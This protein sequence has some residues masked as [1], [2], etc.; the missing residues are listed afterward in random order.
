MNK[1][2]DKEVMNFIKNL[3]Q[4]IEH[5][6]VTD[7]DG[8]DDDHLFLG[9]GKIDIKKYLK[10]LSKYIKKDIYVSIEAFIIKE[11]NNNYRNVKKEEREKLTKESI[12][13]LRKILN[14]N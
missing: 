5:I 3:N 4:Y 2:K 8:D 7:N 10:K 14:D 9:Y 13:I 6:H 11:E 1:Y 12:K